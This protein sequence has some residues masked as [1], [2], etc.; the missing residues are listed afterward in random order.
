MDEIIQKY[1]ER[2]RKRLLE[3]GKHGIMNE[4]DKTDERG[5]VHGTDGKFKKKARRAA[6][7][8]SKTL[9]SGG[10]KKVTA[11]EYAVIEDWYHNRHSGKVGEVCVA[12]YPKGNIVFE[13]RSFEDFRILG[14]VGFDVDIDLLL[15]ILNEKGEEDGDGS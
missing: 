6:A 7:W 3:R 11:R 14:I 12:P 1:R 5:N 10:Y 13:N 9:R 4:D 2:R 8:L 15:E